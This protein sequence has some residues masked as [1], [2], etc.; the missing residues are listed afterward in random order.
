MAE[1][2]MSQL[3]KMQTRIEQLE[4]ALRQLTGAVPKPSENPKDRPDYVER[5]SAQ[6]AALLGLKPAGGEK[7]SIDGWTF[8]D[9]TQYGP[10]AT[11]DF[12]MAMLRQKVSELTSL[13]PA[14]QSADP[15][16]PHFAP[17]IWQAPNPF[18]KITQE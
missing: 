16:L 3:Q 8:E 10:A 18:S 4:S 15:R 11:E 5:G 2:E 9:V 17:P 12:L 14:T 1:K 13:M 7:I 6:H